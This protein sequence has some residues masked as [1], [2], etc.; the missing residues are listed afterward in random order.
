MP[1]C[2]ADECPEIPGTAG[3]AAA[4]TILRKGKME[5]DKTE[6]TALRKRYQATELCRRVMEEHVKEGAFCIDATMGN[7]H[8]TLYLC[9]LAGER[10]RVLAFD[11][12]EEALART[13]E[14]LEK[15][16]P[17]RNYELILDSHSHMERYAGAGS[18]DCIVFNLGYL[19][20]GD[21]G[22]ATKPGTTIKALE[23]ALLL[24]R[25]GGVLSLCIYSGG[26]SGFEERDAVLAWLRSLDAG[27]CLALVTEYYNRPNDPPI[28]ALVIRLC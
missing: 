21:H 20:A 15:N 18:A 25:P 3:C 9:R 16:L 14:R 27:S 28:P 4:D 10:G 2:F 6:E 7:G 5:M 1:V 23:Q 19:P 11:I 13:R 12:Q 22:I 24:L 26:D 8:D 17:Y